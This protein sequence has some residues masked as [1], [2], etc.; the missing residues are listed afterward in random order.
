MAKF[1][2]KPVKVEAFH[3]GVDE[4]PG[5]F[6]EARTEGKV[7][8]QDDRAVITTLEGQMTAEAGD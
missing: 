8:L 3:F 2:K 6:T 1:R 5:W 4:P 7:E